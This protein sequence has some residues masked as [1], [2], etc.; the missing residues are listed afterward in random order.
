MRREFD[1]T[2]ADDIVVDALAELLFGRTVDHIAV[3]ERDNDKFIVITFSDG[4]R[5]LARG[6][7]ILNH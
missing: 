2:D 1:E 3:A 4:T 7:T 5:I 6:L